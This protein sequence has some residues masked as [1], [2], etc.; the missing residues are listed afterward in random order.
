MVVPLELHSK[1]KETKELIDSGEKAEAA[2]ILT[3]VYGT[4]EQMSPMMDNFEKMT[5]LSSLAHGFRQVS[6]VEMEIKLFEELCR[7]AERDLENLGSLATE[8]DIYMTGFDF[9]WLGIAYTRKNMLTEARIALNR[10][11]N[12]LK[13]TKWNIDVEKVIIEGKYYE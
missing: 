1:L 10:A 7:L 6:D 5:I 11:K 2:Q 12:I 9:F 8:S 3:I 13:D 4:Y